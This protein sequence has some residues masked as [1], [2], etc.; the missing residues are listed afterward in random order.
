MWPASSM[1]GRM[2]MRSVPDARTPV[3]ATWWLPLLALVVLATT[4]TAILPGNSFHHSTLIA[5]AVSLTGYGVAWWRIRPARLRTGPYTWVTTAGLPT[6]RTDPPTITLPA[7]GPAPAGR[8]QRWRGALLLINSAAVAMGA[9]FGWSVLSNTLLH[10]AAPSFYRTRTV[11]GG[12]PA[13]PTARWW[14]TA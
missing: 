5:V 4:T 7:V 9:S 8:R 6:D 1:P 14:S 3:P 12:V 2:S 11:L 10:P 13:T